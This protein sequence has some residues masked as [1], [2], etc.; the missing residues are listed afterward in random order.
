MRI[1]RKQAFRVV[2]LALLLTGPAH[3][4]DA[5]ANVRV[6]GSVLKWD[7][8]MEAVNYNVYIWYNARLNAYLTTVQHATEFQL[9]TEG[10]YAVVANGTDYSFSDVNEPG[11]RASFQLSGQNSQAGQSETVSAGKYLVLRKNTC[12]NLLAGDVCTIACD[13]NSAQVA[14]GG[15]CYST[16]G[17]RVQSTGTHDGYVC[18]T[19]DNTVEL[20]AQ[21]YCIYSGRF[22]R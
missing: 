20:Q 17:A 18:E 7:P 19:N 6:E 14:T 9:D 2:L 12:T 21:V 1:L 5:P 22:G 4:V 11:A 8:V 16:D 13:A 15:A 10:V 3:A